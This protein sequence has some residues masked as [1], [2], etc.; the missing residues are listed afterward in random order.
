M[1]GG[2]LSS[3]IVVDNRVIL[4]TAIGANPP[5]SLSEGVRDMRP[6]KPSTPVKFHV[7]CLNLD[8]GSK[9]WEKT[10]LEKQPEYPIHGSN[11]Y[12]TESPATDGKR[13]FVYFAAV[14]GLLAIRFS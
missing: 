5:V 13:I 3:P 6:K 9:L 11:S 2:G 14:F 4:T 8:D 10:I 12:A 7:I 1:P